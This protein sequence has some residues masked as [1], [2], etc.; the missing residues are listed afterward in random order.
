MRLGV[1]PATTPILGNVQNTLES[2]IKETLIEKRII[3]L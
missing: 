3:T 2:I 1:D